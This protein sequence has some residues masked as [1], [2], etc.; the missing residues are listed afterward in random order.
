MAD[1]SRLQPI[2]RDARL[3]CATAGSSDEVRF[4]L[5]R[6][7]SPSVAQAAASASPR[8]PCALSRFTA[9]HS[10]AWLE[11]T[12]GLPSVFS[13]SAIASICRVLVQLRK[14]PSASGRSFS[15]AS[16]AQSCGV[17]LPKFVRLE[18]QRHVG[19]HGDARRGEIVDHRLVALVRRQQHDLLHAERL[20]G[21]EHQPARRHGVDAG[22]VLDD[23]EDFAFALRPLRHRGVGAVEHDDVGMGVRQKLAPR[24]RSR[25]SS[26]AA[27]ASI[28]RRR[29]PAPRG[30]R[31]PSGA[32]WLNCGSL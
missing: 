7:S 5:R 29:A 22:R 15:L 10:T 13:M 16:R 32:K 1:T 31:G 12:T 26:P 2:L 27:A 11:L 3:R 19:D 8:R 23:V 28:R 9:P 25:P 6:S 20:Q 30:C 21:V 24:P 4:L 14:M 18:L 17:T